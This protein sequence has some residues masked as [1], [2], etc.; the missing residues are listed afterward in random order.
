MAE[1]PIKP[2]SLQLAFTSSLI[3]Q[4]EARPELL[5]V[6]RGYSVTPAKYRPLAEHAFPGTDWGA[7]GRID[8]GGATWRALSLDQIDELTAALQALWLPGAGPRVEGVEDTS[9]HRATVELTGAWD[10]Q[11]F[12]H[13]LTM[14][15]SGYRGAE[16]SA[17]RSCARLLLGLGGVA[18][19]DLAW[20]EL[21]VYGEP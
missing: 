4:L 17:Y 13:Q 18:E 5:I 14:H 6:V 9:K 3:S 8:D 10:G 2:F 15:S 11:A 1:D 12:A 7:L 20:L 16:A 19:D 21:C